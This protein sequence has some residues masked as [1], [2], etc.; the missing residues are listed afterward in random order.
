MFELVFT[1]FNYAVVIVLMMVGLYVIFATQNLIKKLVGEFDPHFEL[2]LRG[3]FP[4]L[5]Y[6]T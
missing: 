2:H 5:R 4:S 3:A 6:A 1:H